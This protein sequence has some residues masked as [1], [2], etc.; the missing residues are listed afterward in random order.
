MILVNGKPAS[1]VRVSDRGLQYG[2]G[3]FETLAVSHGQCLCMDRHL[4]RLTSGCHALEIPALGETELKSDLRTVSHG[5]ARGVV[6]III[7]RGA[8]ARGYRTS[9]AATPT[10]I[11]SSHPWPPFPPPNRTEGIALRVCRT[12]LS[13]N[14]RLAGLKHLNRLEQVL[15]VNEIDDPRFSEGLM[16][17]TEGVVVEGTMSNLFYVVGGRLRT[18]EL[19]RCGVHGIIRAEILDWARSHLDE[20]VELTRDKPE[21]VLESEEC[22]VCNSLIGIW[23]V[24]EIE[25]RKIPLG[26]MTESIRSDLEAAKV[27]AAD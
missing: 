11:V 27:I 13:I 24:R 2:D 9:S 14:T 3:L 6:K 1:S 5:V 8:G 26:T 18:P 4:A 25:S 21:T 23:P 10:R 16:L 19:S 20:P 17:D 15:A 22:F 12:R 7:T